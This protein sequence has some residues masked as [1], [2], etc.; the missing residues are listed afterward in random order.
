MTNESIFDTNI[1]NL[2]Q[3]VNDDELASE[4]EAISSVLIN[5]AVT[6]AKF[7]LT[8]DMPNKNKQRIPESEFD[9]LIRTGIYMPIKMAYEKMGDHKEAF[10]L[11]VI[12]HLKKAG[13]QIKALAAFW[14]QERPKDIEYIKTAL[15][16]KQP[17]N[18]SWE[19]QYADSDLEDDGITA[20]K[21]TS[22]KGVVIVA[23]PAYAGRTP[24]L[25]I[26]SDWSTAYLKE[27]PDDSFLYV[28]KQDDGS[29]LRL[30]PYKN[31]DGK[32]NKE[33]IDEALAS[34]SYAD[35]P[36]DVKEIITVKVS[37]IPEPV[38]NL[39]S[40]NN[41][42]EDNKVDELDILKTKVLDLERALGEKDA[43]IAALQAQLAELPGLQE[44]KASIDKKEAE[45][46]QL[47]E[48]KKL[49][50]EAKIEKP[51]SYFDENKEKFLSLDKSGLEFFVQ[52]LA[53][54]KDASA[55][56]NKEDKKP[57]IPPM[58]GDIITNEPSMAELVEGLKARHNPKKET[59]KE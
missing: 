12:T 58:T 44:F 20:L 10:P 33:K 28:K 37:E 32:I 45:A 21:D 38:I 11:G 6:W 23:T 19:I 30:F 52:E 55:S 18:V 57:K 14:S 51:E 42:M 17:V 4:N 36:S 59:K 39:Q 41:N 47:L 25:A 31:R 46:S 49:F 54:F 29:T 16:S 24:I 43:T 5:P 56:E 50:T 13:K 53:S 9:N 35:L 2:V 40:E 27:L 7:I 8:D 22:L 48:I 26:A 15:A 34:T 3:L 1:D